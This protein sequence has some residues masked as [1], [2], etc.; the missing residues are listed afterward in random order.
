MNVLQLESN[1]R[2]SAIVSTA[3]TQLTQ[4]IVTLVRLKALLKEECFEK[5]QAVN[6]VAVRVGNLDVPKS[7]VNATKLAYCAVISANVS[8]AK[9]MNLSATVR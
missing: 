4:I 3:I 1:V 8:I 2:K 6:I 5:T 9:I 7:T